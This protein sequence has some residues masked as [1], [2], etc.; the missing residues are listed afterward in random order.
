[1]DVSVIPRPA[2]GDSRGLQRQRPRVPPRR[3]DPQEEGERPRRHESVEL[4]C[5]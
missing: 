5:Y 4:Y 1:M 2:P 3:E